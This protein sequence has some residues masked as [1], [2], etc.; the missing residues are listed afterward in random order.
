MNKD[1]V[2]KIVGVAGSV[3]GIAG[4]L[5]SS[6]HGDKKMKQTVAEEVAKKLSEQAKE[7]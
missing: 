7:S 6:W 4:G 2:I 3:L 1:T 5:L